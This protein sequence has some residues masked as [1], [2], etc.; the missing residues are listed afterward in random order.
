[1]ESIVEIIL[2]MI[3]KIPGAFFRWLFSGC[4]R[5]LKKFINNGD[6]YLD[7]IIG[8]TMVVIIVILVTKL[9]S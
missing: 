2:L 5:P 1:M 6:A 9:I 8:L 3:F 7:G 4:K